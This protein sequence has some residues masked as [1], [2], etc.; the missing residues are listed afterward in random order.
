MTPKPAQARPQKFR[1][2]PVKFSASGPKVHKFAA[3]DTSFNFGANAISDE[4]AAS[5]RKKGRR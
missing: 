2:K 5:I 3:P 1:P 4:E